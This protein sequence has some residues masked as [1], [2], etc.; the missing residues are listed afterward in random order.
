MTTHDVAVRVAAFA[1][2]LG[3]AAPA[4][5]DAQ[6]DPLPVPAR[7]VDLRGRELRLR[8]DGFFRWVE[9]L[10]VIDMVPNAQSDETNEDAEPNLAVDPG[11]TSHIVGSAFTPNP[12]GG[13]TTAPVFVSTDG[14]SNWALRNIVPSGNGMTGDISLAFG[15][16]GGTLYT[17]I[18]RGGS[19][20]RQ[21][22]LR[23]T[24]PFLGGTMDILVDHSTVQMDQPF[25]SATT[26]LV[27]GSDRDRA[28]AGFNFFGQRIGSG[29][30]GRTAS[31]E[32]S[33]DARTAAAP[34][35]FT[36]TVVET[37]AT[38]QQDMPAVRYAVHDGGVIYGAFYR[39]TGTATP[40]AVCDVIVVRDDAFAAGATPFADL[41]DPGDGVAGRIVATGR[42]VPAF[43]ASLGQNRLVASNVSIAVSPSDAGLVYVAWA[44]SDATSFY[45][46]HVRRSADSG[47]TWSGD[48]LTI[49]TATNPALAINS[50]G[51]VAFLYQQLTGT[52]ASRRWG[53]HLRRTTTGTTWS[54]LV[55]ADTPNSAGT[56]FMG[57]YLDLLAV[58]R[59]FY[60]VFPALNTPD[61]AN[62]PQGVTFRRNV[63]FTT[64]QVRNLANTAN[65]TA[66]ID[67]FFFKL[68]SL[69][70]LDR[71]FLVPRLCTTVEIDRGRLV[72]PVD[73][74][75]VR[76]LDPVPRNCTLKWECPGCPEG[77]CP[78]WYHMFFDD[79]DPEVW[80]VQL[81]GRNGDLVKQQVSRVGRGMVLSFR[82]SRDN[83]R[84]K[85]IGDYTLAF[86]SI[87]PVE[88]GRH[89]FATHL[90]VSAYPQQE[91]LRRRAA[92]R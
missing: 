55:L 54:D 10:S 80:R 92:R 64:H 50:D 17:G 1:V 82:P 83:H 45:T 63:N 5:A 42:T 46:L 30:T 90:E 71:C 78:G 23:T 69:R 6:G 22:M 9:R 8:F 33:Q 87:G 72:I 38:F 49:P 67:P 27:S 44:D 3:G 81:F 70:V 60:G 7:I 68:E 58:G 20:L 75:P 73:T 18:L 88:R 37:R 34:A 48:L 21:M 4:V 36:N 86:E 62:F 47:S 57:D 31:V 52:G 51:V 59:T 40:S 28:F 32:R 65:V 74:L 26:S 85:D 11:N 53:T 24:D 14:G 15:T 56:V 43:P 91:H 76:A 84:E 25:M 61:N 79:M 16:R 13:T 41:D 39:W 29:G 35:G 77:L 19:F 89:A 12:T 66:S 2:L